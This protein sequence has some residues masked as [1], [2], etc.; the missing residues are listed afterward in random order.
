ME[1]VAF[2]DV[3][4]NLLRVALSVALLLADWGIVGLAIAA[5]IVNVF[6]GVI[7]TGFVH[8][9]VPWR[10][11]RI[12][13]AFCR[14]AITEATPLMVNQLLNIFFFRVDVLLL[15]PLTS[16]LVVGYYGIAYKFIDGLGFISSYV[17]QALF[18][19]LARSARDSREVTKQATV[20]GLRVL[21][22]LALPIAAGTVILA[23]PIVRL[24]YRPEMAPAIPALQVLVLFLPFSFL[25]G[26][27]QYV[28]IA[29]GRQRLITVGY[30]IACMFNVAANLLAIHYWS[31]LGA[32]GVT[33]ASEL[34]LLVPFTWLLRRDLGALPWGTIFVRPALAA[35]IMAV[36]VSR[37]HGV[38]ALALPVGMLSYSVALGITGGV[39][40]EDF[41]LLWSITGRGGTITPQPAIVT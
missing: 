5:L 36:A 9:L 20:F 34:V 2:I 39:T 7:Y 25:N 28:L 33:V 11:L 38:L 23:G 3:A 31:Y 18:P 10:A 27:L 17:T 14:W 15:K 21:M 32:A 6:N 22:L 1:Y 26:L 37:C 4:A 16:D 29:L 12:D 13:L 35:L 24:F 19:M 8:R 40:R 30:I 41:R